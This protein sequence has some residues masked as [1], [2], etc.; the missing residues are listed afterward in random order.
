MALTGSPCDQATRLNV[1]HVCHGAQASSP[2]VASDV[3]ALDHSVPGRA[4]FLPSHMPHCNY[5]S[6]AFFATATSVSCPQH[7]LRVSQSCPV[8]APTASITPHPQIFHHSL[9][10]TSPPCWWDNYASFICTDTCGP[11]HA[12]NLSGLQRTGTTP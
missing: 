5:F 1:L 9:G 3:G 6:A 4:V 12:R 11:V 8:I 7:G 2:Q 10:Q